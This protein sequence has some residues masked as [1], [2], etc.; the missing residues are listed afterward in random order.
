MRQKKASSRIYKLIKASIL[1]AAVPILLIYLLVDSPGYRL[2]NAAE[3]VFVP[4]VSTI[5]DGVSYP[6]RAAGRGINGFRELVSAKRENKEL[7]KML[8]AALARNNECEVIFSENQNL[9]QKLDIAQENPKTVA[10]ARVLHNNAIMDRS[11]FLLSKGTESGIE[12]GMTVISFDGF[13]VGIVTESY[14]G[15]AFVRSIRDPKSSIPVRISGTDVFGFL[16][17]RGLS[18]PELEFLSD[19]EF[20]PTAGLHLQTHGIKG[21]MPD[22]IPIGTLMNKFIPGTEVSKLTEVMVVK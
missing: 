15:G 2:L 3:R 11:G 10:V 7:R 5:A 4:V 21:N 19:P 20:Q 1:A 14:A 8:D 17:G 12:V 16:A 6:F 13:L 9:E 18:S 22:G